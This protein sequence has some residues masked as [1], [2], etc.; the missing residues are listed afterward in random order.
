MN[1]IKRLW[2][3]FRLL[4]F[5]HGIQAAQYLRKKHIFREMGG[6]CSWHSK[7]IP[8]EPQNVSLGRNVHVASN[9]TFI[10]HDIIS[11]MFWKNPRY[12]SFVIPWHTGTI[13]IH[14]DVV[15]GANST[16]LYDVEIGE[17]SIIAA[18]SVVTKNVPSGEIW[19]GGYQLIA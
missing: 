13:M 17:N 12:S 15:I 16:I 9:C 6:D 18:G 7:K 11:D 2:I 3:M 4:F 1:R 5:S 8:S 19:G 14:D 10:T